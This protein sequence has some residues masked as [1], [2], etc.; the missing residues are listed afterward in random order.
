MPHTTTQMPTTIDEA[1]EFLTTVTKYVAQTLT[2]MAADDML[3][4]TVFAFSDTHVHVIDVS[5]YFTDDMSKFVFAQIAPG[6]AEYMRAHTV[7]FVAEAWSVKVRKDE[8]D[9][10]GTPDHVP[11]SQHLDRQEVTYIVLQTRDGLSTAC[12]YP[13]LLD[14]DGQHRYL[15]ETPTIEPSTAMRVA[16]SFDFFPQATS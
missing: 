11:A 7:V 10:L 9:R 4:H 2:R 12:E 14:E 15:A 3:P 5:D 6:L 16:T 13:L 8:V 1:K